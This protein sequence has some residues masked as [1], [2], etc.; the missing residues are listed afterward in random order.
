M[1]EGDQWQDDSDGISPR[2]LNSQGRFEVF[3]SE[4]AVCNGLVAGGNKLDTN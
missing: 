1:Y 4:R 3:L 2:E